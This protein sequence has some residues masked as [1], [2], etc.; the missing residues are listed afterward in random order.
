[1]MFTQRVH[2]FKIRNVSLINVKF[3][4]KLVDAESGTPDTG[5]Y[6]VF[7]KQGVISPQCDEWLTVKFQPTEC[8]E[9]NVRLLMV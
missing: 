5:Y 1:M 7:P 9:D 6:S 4:C 2:Q 3:R 8:D